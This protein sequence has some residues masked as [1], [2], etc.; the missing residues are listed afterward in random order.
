MWYLS[1]LLACLR[2]MR[3]RKRRA[4]VSRTI[5]ITIDQNNPILIV[6]HV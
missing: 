3:K 4:S 6:L 2:S 1:E 5:D